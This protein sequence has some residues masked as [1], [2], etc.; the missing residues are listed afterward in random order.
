MALAVAADP[1]IWP[2]AREAI[3]AGA[4]A[5]PWVCPEAEA[6]AEVATTVPSLAL[7][8]ADII[9]QPDLAA[10]SAVTPLL[11]PVEAAAAVGCCFLTI[12]ITRVS[13]AEAITGSVRCD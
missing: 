10:A 7:L 1:S 8:G 12:C 4:V 9:L 6:E 11:A 2:L 13:T 3:P 5:L